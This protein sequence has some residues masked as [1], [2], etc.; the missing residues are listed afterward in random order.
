M[1]PPRTYTTG[2]I[3]RGLRALTV[4]AV[5]GTSAWILVRY[6]GLSDIVAT[7]FDASGHPDSF[8]P[9]WSILVLGG[10][11]LVLSLGIVALSS[12]PRLF[13]YPVRITEENAQAVYREGERMLVWTG[14]AIQPIYLGIAWSVIVGGG[15]PLIVLGA[16]ALLAACAMGIVRM[17]RAGRR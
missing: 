6:P 9:R 4:L 3:T 7:H 15:A 10:L 13:N 2:P 17:V 14:L 1:R 16:V 11:M 8:G 12:R 5:L